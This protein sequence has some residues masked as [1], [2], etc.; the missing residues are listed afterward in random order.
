[1]MLGDYLYPDHLHWELTPWWHWRCWLLGKSMRRWTYDMYSIG[2][3]YDGA[4]RYSTYE[5]CAHEALRERAGLPDAA[6]H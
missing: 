3:T 6:S 5:E 2:S 1:M 4:W